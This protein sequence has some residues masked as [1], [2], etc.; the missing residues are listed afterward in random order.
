M[1]ILVSLAATWAGG[2]WFR[3]WAVAIALGCFHEWLAMAGGRASRG[4]KLLGWGLLV[5]VLVL[6]ALGAH[7]VYLLGATAIAT[8]AVLAHARLAGESGALWQ[9]VPYAAFPALSFALLRGN[10]NAGLFA[11]LFLYAVVWA[12]DIFAYFVGRAVGGPKLAP[13][14]SPGKTW[15]G[16]VGGAAFGVLAGLLVASYGTPA[17]GIWFILAGA[18]VLSALS[19]AGDLFESR[20]K[21]R[22]GHKDSGN[23]IPGHGGMMDRVDGLVA[24]AA[25]LYVYAALA[26]GADS[27]ALGLFLP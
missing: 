13:K 18:L 1:L 7:A 24:G 17:H 9:A 21:R 11:I 8:L 12:T 15:S 22:Y 27:P 19:Q 16:A 23:L 5:V 14:I 25:A 10:D 3:L 26:G 6:V 4:H 2:V 20:L